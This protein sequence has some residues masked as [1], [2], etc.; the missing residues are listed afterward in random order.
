MENFKDKIGAVV[1]IAIAVFYVWASFSSHPKD[2][3]AEND[4]GVLRR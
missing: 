2:Y 1:L 3:S 4:Y